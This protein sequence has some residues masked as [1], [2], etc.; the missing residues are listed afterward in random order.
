M[1]CGGFCLEYFLHDILGYINLYLFLYVYDIF[2]LFLL[3]CIVLLL[4]L[5]LLLL[6]VFIV[7][8]F[9]HEPPARMIPRMIP[10]PLIDVNKLIVWLLFSALFLNTTTK[11]G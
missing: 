6:T 11:F 2:N 4:L 5:L 7:I 10:I 1:G 8:R 9:I 3:K